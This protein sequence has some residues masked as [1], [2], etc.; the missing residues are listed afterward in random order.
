MPVDKDQGHPDEKKVQPR[1]NHT[2][3][4]AVSQ[5][6]EPEIKIPKAIE[7]F[8]TK[9]AGIIRLARRIC[10]THAIVYRPPSPLNYLSTRRLR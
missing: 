5:N 6:N 7:R 3:P 10:V 2:R 1:T 8:A 9:T 4:R